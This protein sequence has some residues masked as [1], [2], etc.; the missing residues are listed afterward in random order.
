MI[1][2]SR[3]C[4]SKLEKLTSTTNDAPAAPAATAITAAATL[5]A[6]IELESGRN[7]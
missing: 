2:K 1:I 7:C 3:S 4:S 5:I 6:E